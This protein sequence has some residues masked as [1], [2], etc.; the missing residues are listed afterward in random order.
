LSKESL[1]FNKYSVSKLELFKACGVREALLMKRS[2]LIYFFKTAQVILV[3]A[4]VYTMY[5]SLP[6][7]TK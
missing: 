1:S 4:L 2:I 6:F 7:C 3:T 5:N